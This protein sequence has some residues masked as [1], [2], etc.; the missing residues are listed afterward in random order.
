MV[1]KK[2]GNLK[3]RC[4]FYCS[5]RRNLQRILQGK[6]LIIE[7]D[8]ISKL[9]PQYITRDPHTK[10]P[11]G[12]ILAGIIVRHA[13]VVTNSKIGNSSELITRLRNTEKR[14]EKSVIHFVLVSSVL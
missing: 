1:P 5:R 8:A 9:G 7:L 6:G 13:L 12:I 10:S 2:I 3:K 14:V 11:N 4:L